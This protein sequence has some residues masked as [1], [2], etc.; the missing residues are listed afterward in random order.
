MAEKTHACRY[1]TSYSG[2]KLPLKRVG[3]LDEGDMRTRN[4]YFCGS[5]NAA[6]QLIACEKIVYG[7][8]EFRHSYRYY[9]DGK[10]AQANIDD[11]SG[12]T[13]VLDYPA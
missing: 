6:D 5:F 13:T 8:I 12:E 1:F 10:L 3:D 11:G 9:P 4:T 7:E 2:A